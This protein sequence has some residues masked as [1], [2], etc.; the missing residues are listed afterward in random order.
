MM[1]RW[2]VAFLS[3]AIALSAGRAEAAQGM[4]SNCSMTVTGSA[5]NI[6]FPASGNTGPKSPNT[7]L[8][9]QNTS[10]D[11]IWFNPFGTATTAS[12]S[13][14]LAPTAGYNFTGDDPI[15]ATVSVISDGTSSALT[16]WY[17]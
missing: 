1:L 10:S 11:N 14:K 6:T 3:A 17:R 8:T 2:V 13:W 5:A 4:L 15:P 9:L 7:Y 16:C 12:P